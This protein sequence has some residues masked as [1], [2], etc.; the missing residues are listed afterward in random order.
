MEHDENQVAHFS[1]NLRLLC[2][3]HGSISAVCR[4]INLNRQQFN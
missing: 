3:R 4:K 2:E 1:A